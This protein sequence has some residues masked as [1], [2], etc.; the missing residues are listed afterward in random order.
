MVIKECLRR[1]CHTFP[2]FYSEFKHNDVVWY[3]VI[4]LVFFNFKVAFHLHAILTFSLNKNFTTFFLF[5]WIVNNESFTVI[6]HF[7]LLL[8]LIFLI[9]SQKENNFTKFKYF[10]YVNWQNYSV[11]LI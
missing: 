6:V 4:L 7:V 3:E 9:L 1:K 10:F 5:Y 11:F 8:K 2:E